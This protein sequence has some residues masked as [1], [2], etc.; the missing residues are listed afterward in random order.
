MPRKLEPTW[1]TGA[2][3]EL[4]RPST[5][6]IQ[7]RAILSD[8]GI[9]SAQQGR[10][11]F[12][13][14]T[15]LCSKYCGWKVQS[16]RE[17]STAQSR[18]TLV[19]LADKASKVSTC[20]ARFLELRN[21]LV[22]CDDTAGFALQR[23][24]RILTTAEQP[25]SDRAFKDPGSFAANPLIVRQ[26][27]LEALET[28]GSSRGPAAHHNLVLQICELATFYKQLRGE[29]PTHSTYRRTEYLSAPQS[30]FGRFCVAFFRH[31]DR[32]LP[33]TRVATAIREALP[34]WKVQTRS[35][36]RVS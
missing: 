1:T 12:R 16:S 31:F 17:P 9:F 4:P 15:I 11:G 6:T 8:R 14:L 21:L 22:S 24:M 3:V 28:L 35:S 19:V 18:R 2:L 34:E 20:P 10:E 27:A 36:P 25:Y 30:K 23:R 32:S 13:D 29:E 33:A 5:F 7:A 26:A